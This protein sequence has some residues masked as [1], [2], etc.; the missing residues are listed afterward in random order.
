MEPWAKRLYD[1]LV[2]KDNGK[3]NVTALAR[4]VRASQPTV[5]QWFKPKKG[6]EVTKMIEADNAVRAA[7]YAGTTVEYIFTGRGSKSSQ[8]ARLDEAKLISVLETVE[9]ALLKSERTMLPRR[10]AQIVASMYAGKTDNA[11]DAAEL[12]LMSV[13]SSLEEA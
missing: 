12:A 13:L 2:I 7:A 11:A 4:A 5:S 10:K 1:L 3:V 8:S 6:G 9:S